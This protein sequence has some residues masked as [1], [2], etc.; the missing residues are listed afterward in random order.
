MLKLGD[1]REISMLEKNWS[2]LQTMV[3]IDCR[4]R[5]LIK[6]N[7]SNWGR[8]MNIDMSQLI[9]LDNTSHQLK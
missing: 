1:I 3:M 7:C 4:M 6:V 9:I 5:Y 8:I 2:V